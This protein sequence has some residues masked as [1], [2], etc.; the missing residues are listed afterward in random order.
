MQPQDAGGGF[1]WTRLA[2]EAGI[3][4]ASGV[5]TAF[6]TVWKWGRGGAKAEQAIKDDYTAK[7]EAQGKE[8]RGMIAGIE[9]AAD[10]RLNA[11]VDQFK[12]SFDGMR[13][14]M[15]QNLL[16]AERRFLSNERFD[17]FYEEYR[18]DQRRT[19]DKLER[20]LGMRQ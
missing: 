12:E 6:Y 13:R 20:L 19:D 16:D 11:L 3:A 15:D 1:D 2:A 7:I 8:L 17:H 10:E 18:K 14:Q 5:G 4:I 9:K